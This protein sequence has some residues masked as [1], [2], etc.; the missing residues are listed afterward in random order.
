MTTSSRRSED[1]VKE[2]A[3]VLN[4]GLRAIPDFVKQYSDVLLEVIDQICVDDP[5]IIDWTVPFPRNGRNQTKRSLINY[6]TTHGGNE[7]LM[8]V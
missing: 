1:E 5:V 3:K 6:I 2:L 4:L 8:L 7:N